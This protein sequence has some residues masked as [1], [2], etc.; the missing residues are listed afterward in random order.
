MRDFIARN[1]PGG[2]FGRVDEIANVVVFLASPRASWVVGAS[3]N[4]DGGQS[5][6]NI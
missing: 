4:V 1:I 5:H 3:I 6:S 2:R